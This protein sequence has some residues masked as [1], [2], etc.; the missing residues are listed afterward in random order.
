M[1]ATITLETVQAELKLWLAARSAATTG[2]SV[3]VNGRSLSTQDLPEMTKMINQ[4][5]RQEAEFLRMKQQRNKKRRLGSLGR[6]V[7]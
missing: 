6:M 5:S 3:S 1:P 7:N 2:Q 4:L